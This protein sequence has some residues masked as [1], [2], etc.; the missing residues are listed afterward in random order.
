VVWLHW[1]DGVFDRGAVMCIESNDDSDGCEVLTPGG[2]TPKNL[3]RAVKPGEA[4]R[5]EADGT[6]SIVPEEPRIPTKEDDKQ[7]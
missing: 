5:R 3:V 2:F 6:Y 1:V 7:S 4:V